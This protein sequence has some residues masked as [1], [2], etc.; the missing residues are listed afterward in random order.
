M[1]NRTIPFEKSFASHEKAIYWSEKNELKPHEITSGTHNK[2]W[3]KC[4]C[5]HIFDIEISKITTRNQWCGYCSTPSRKL[6]DNINCISCFEKSFASHKNAIY[7]SNINKIKARNVFKNSSDKYFFDC[8]NCSH[9]FDMVL[10][11]ISG[12]NSW[13]HYCS[14]TKLCEDYN[15]KICF[16]KSFASHEKAIYWSDKNELKPYQVF[17]KTNKK[18]LFD[19]DNCNHEF[20]IVPNSIVTSN[21]WCSYCV[22]QKLCEDNNCVS[23]FEKSFASHEKVLYWSNKNIIEPR[24]VF[25][26]SRKK[27]IFNCNVCNHNFEISLD[28]LSKNG[29]C[30]YCSNNYLCGNN[31]CNI[32]FEKSFA[33]INKSIFWSDKNILKPIQVFKNTHDKYLFDCNICNHEFEQE[34]STVSKNGWC[35]Y[36]CNP[37]KILCINDNCVDCYNKSFASHKKAIF[38]SEKNKFKPRQVFLGSNK[39][40]IFNCNECNNDYTAIL[41]SI[42]KNNC[43]CSCKKNKTEDILFQKL[44]NIY[45]ITRQ[46][47]VEWCKNKSYLPFDFCLEKYKIIIELDGRQH[48][49]QVENWDSPEKTQQNDKYKMNCA[50]TNGFSVIR[51]LQDDI[52]NDKY[53][54]ANQ[55]VLNIEKIILEDKVQNIYMCKNNEYDNLIKLCKVKIN[56]STKNKVVKK[57]EENLEELEKELFG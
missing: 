53:D 32:C 19:C 34:L 3:F 11:D 24:Q 56:R 1:T 38:W 6:C 10:H 57:E 44:K 40:C 15:C 7:W 13:C 42:T 28:S 41:Y 36:C 5:N 49:V 48:F 18:Y 29:W 55:L 39:K 43:W 25:K 52:F 35:H 37:P 2:Y 21:N 51:I 46:Y 45:N 12:N 4:N 47:K 22:N 23:C 8:I 50:Y 20:E 31:N 33:S 17:K 14:N 9:I 27:C 30:N 16:E 26:K 54:W